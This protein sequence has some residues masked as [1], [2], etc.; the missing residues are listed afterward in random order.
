MPWSSS[1]TP[2]QSG[3][4]FVIT[5]S[6]SGIGLEAAKV[7]SRKG[8]HVVMACRNLEKAQ[9]ARA[10][11]GGTTEVRHLDTASLES[12]R[13]FADG[14]D[15][16]VDVLVNNAGI[17]AVPQARTTDGFESQLGTNFLGHFALTGLLLPRV[18]DRV[19]TLSSGAHRMGRINL[20]DP[21][22]E[23]RR[24]RRWSAYGQSKLA[25]LMFAYELQ[26]RLLLAGSSVRSIAAHPGYA[27]TN[28][29]ASMG[30]AAVA[31]QGVLLR[32]GVV[33]D[34]A[35]G[36]EPTLYAATAPDLPGGSFVG[37][38]GPGEMSGPAQ[39]VGSSSASR[40]LDVQRGLW[41]LAVRLTGVDPG[42]P[43]DVVA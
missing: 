33:Q 3:R 20:E 17:M 30:R 21:N 25:D 39:I 14:L 24:Y 40:D 15:G 8:A 2:D 5:G 23:N 16:E 41:D 42:L 18:T 43:A 37:P 29:Q 4:T 7:L 9:Q 36:A 32:V 38:S 28:L 22:W 6:N 10:E 31:V 34:A 1:E 27:A 26:R 19:V 11:V 35:G 12:V 13:A